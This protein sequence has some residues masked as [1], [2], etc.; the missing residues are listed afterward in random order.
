VTVT[1]IFVA[2]G[3]VAVAVVHYLL[4]R[5]DYE[6]MTARQQELTRRRGH[7]SPR[8]GNPDWQQ[9]PPPPVNLP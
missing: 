3:T 9:P 7:G 1:L 4:S 5:R 2:A 8:D 6:Q